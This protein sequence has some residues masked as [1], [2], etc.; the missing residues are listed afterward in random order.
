MSDHRSKLKQLFG[1]SMETLVT[2]RSPLTFLF[3]KSLLYTFILPKGTGTVDLAQNRI[4]FY[5]KIAIGLSLRKFLVFRSAHSPKT[6]RG[7][8]FQDSPLTKHKKPEILGSAKVLEYYHSEKF[9][10]FGVSVAMQFRNSYKLQNN[11]VRN[12]TV[13]NSTVRNKTFHQVRLDV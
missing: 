9:W 5:L 10:F 1:R 6:K 4:C 3:S 11:K 8:A 7:N 2:T 13:G 12:S